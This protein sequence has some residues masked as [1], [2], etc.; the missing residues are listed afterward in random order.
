MYGWTGKVL[1]VDLTKPR[2][3]V[4]ELNPKVARDF[5]GGRGLGV[6]YLY[7]EIDPKVDDLS[8]ENKLLMV[9]GPLTGTGCPG[10]CH[11]PRHGERKRERRAGQ[12]GLARG[13]LG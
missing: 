3:K 10:G 5:I 11:L 8:P 1:R 13:D 4:E 2:I 12:G 9:T 7:D 6:R